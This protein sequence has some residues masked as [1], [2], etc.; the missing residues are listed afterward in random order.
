MTKNLVIV[1]SPAKA[2]TIEKILGNEFTVRAS[3]GHIR[4]LP[5]GDNAVDVAKN[6][7]PHYEV[8]PDKQKVVRELKQL[9]K[10]AEVVWLA[11]DEDRE[12]ESISWHLA[13]V[14]GLDTLRTRRIVFHEITSKAIQ[15]AVENYRQIDMNLVNAQQARRVLDRVVGFSLS[16]IL[17][18][19]VKAGLSAGRVQS[20]A[21]R[22]VVEREREIRDFAV[23][24]FYKVTADFLTPAHQKFRAELETH[25]A[26]KAH[27]EDFLRLC[28]DARYTVES[29][30]VKPGKRT[31]PPPFTTSTLQQDASRKL[32]MGVQRV[33]QLA[34][35]LYEEGHITYMRTD[36]V[37][38]S[39]EALFNAKRHITAEY[40]EKYHKLRK[41]KS[42]SANAQ[43]AH[44]AI[45][46]TRFDNPFIGG[47]PAR[48][49]LYE[50]IWKRALA[51]Q[52]ADAELEIT[53]VKIRVD[54]KALPQGLFTKPADVP[55]FVAKGEVIRFD[56]FLKLYPTIADDDKDEEGDSAILPD[57]H[58]GQE[59]TN[60]VIR[61]TQRFTRP[62]A[63]YTEA[64]LVKKLEEIG[65][66][67]PSTYAATIATI[68]N[69]GYVAKEDRE[70]TP[71]PY[72]Q[73]VLDAGTI[74][75]AKLTELVGAERQKFFPTD[76]GLLVNDFLVQ[77]FT[78]V[79]DYNF[80]AKLEEEFDEISRGELE[81]RQMMHTFYGPFKE[82]VD[83]TLLTAERAAGERLLGTD[84]KTG[85]PVIARMG[86][87]GP[88]VQLGAAEDEVKRF[89]NLLPSQRL[90]TLT[91]EDALLLLEDRLLGTD[92]KTGKNVY[93]RSG[94]YGPLVQVGE[95]EDPDKRMASLAKGQK[96]D[97]ITLEDAL[98]LLELPRIL[99]KHQEQVVKAN[100]GRFGPYVQW[101][102]L[103]ASIPKTSD[104]YS[105]TLEEAI[106]LIQ[107]K[108]KAEAEKVMRTFEGTDIQLV[109]GR[110]GPILM[111][112]KDT[113]R[114]P[115]NVKVEEMTTEQ[116]LKILA[117]TDPIPARGAK[118]KAK[119]GGKATKSAST[120]TAA[121][122]KRA[123]TGKPVDASELKPTAP[124]KTARKTTTRK[125]TSAPT[126]KATGTKAAAKTPKK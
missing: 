24:S 6:F 49:R 57:M 83:N 75:E 114:V 98:H 55:A 60:E 96:L 109:K 16:P 100:V 74:T 37:N 14:L 45:R 31:P 56:G 104:V 106:T 61:A 89:G 23:E 41:Y 95:K 124:K 1:E 10:Q 99:G 110:F 116:A 36:S 33:M 117:E 115:K 76:L 82:Q 27:A 123:T 73:L 28:Q 118:G 107:A 69:R 84:P 42:K 2:K 34:Q 119:G 88:L 90:D 15:H 25:L 111:Q 47:D 108:Q 97:T 70:G 50:L 5:K 32:Y 9:C 35:E 85:K 53:K 58:Q 13:Q 112:G 72:I 65:V 94:L 102:S 67:R 79:V 18:K 113:W 48:Q 125:A 46:P 91:L 126:R 21:V 7:E 105:L 80:T 77:Y 40:G 101:G 26:L 20:V 19:K 17:W 54:S 43:E 4:D 8:P 44:E 103:F 22:L 66:G 68:Q 92:P 93:V 11:T 120:Q 38:L 12:G 121:K 63:R 81:W 87:Y 78:S 64:S 71:R 122:A 39:D 51:S 59:L 30:E 52:M 86:K 3:Y 62:P 29:K